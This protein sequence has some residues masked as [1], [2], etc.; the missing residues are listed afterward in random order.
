MWSNETENGIHV[1]R[2][3]MSW[4]RMGGKLRTG[5]DYD[6]FEAWLKTLIVD[7]KNLSDQDVNHILDL[8]KNGKMELEYLA[9][10]FLATLND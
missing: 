4:V 6:N 9:K 2:F 1:T 10:Q 5:K 3:I 7:G 8:S